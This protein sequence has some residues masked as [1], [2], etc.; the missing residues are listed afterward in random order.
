MKF[1]L[2]VLGM[3][4]IIEGAPYMIAPEK[5]KAWARMMQNLDGRIVRV[6]GMLCLAAGVVLLYLTRQFIG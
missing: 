6:L 3:V 5:M 4:L 1:F 2:T